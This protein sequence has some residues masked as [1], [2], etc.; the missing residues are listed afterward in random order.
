MSNLPTVSN[1]SRK[2]FAPSK[3]RAKM[4]LKGDFCEKYGV[5]NNTFYVSIF[6]KASKPMSTKHSIDENFFIRRKEF[7]KRVWLQCHENYYFLSRHLKDYEL[8]KILSIFTSNIQSWST[9]ISTNMFTTID[10]RGI[11]DYKVKP[12][13]WQFFRLTT[14]IIRKIFKIARVKR[15]NRDLSVLIERG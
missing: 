10:E 15:E 7:S 12:K 13:M 2:S 3:K 6:K 9:F 8:S 5:D 4:I 14:A 11:F 1:K